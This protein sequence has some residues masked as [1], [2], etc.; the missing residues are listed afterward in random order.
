LDLRS[1]PIYNANAARGAL[2]R[3]Q[4]RGLRLKIYC[5]PEA[6]ISCPAEAER[7]Q[8]AG[9]LDGQSSEKRNPEFI[10][11]HCPVFKLHAE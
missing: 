1:E 3:N 9:F 7:I 10:F 4:R 6:T 2:Q 5:K 11:L 8:Q